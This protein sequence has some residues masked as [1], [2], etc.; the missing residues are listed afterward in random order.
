MFD[1]HRFRFVHRQLKVARARNPDGGFDLSMLNLA[2]PQE[3]FR[4]KI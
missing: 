1:G 2:N 3:L 4:K